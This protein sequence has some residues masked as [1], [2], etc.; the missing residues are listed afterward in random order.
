MQNNY[1]YPVYEVAIIKNGQVIKIYPQEQYNREIIEQ[2]KGNPSYYGGI[3]PTVIERHTTVTRT[4]EVPATPTYTQIN[5]SSELDNVFEDGL[6]PITGYYYQ[7][8][9]VFA[10]MII[11]AIVC[12]IAGKKVD[13]VSISIG[14]IIAMLYFFLRFINTMG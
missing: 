9:A 14:G 1:A 5:L 3:E 7:L 10:A 11:V 6:K 13:I 12:K 8:A 2:Y 4:I